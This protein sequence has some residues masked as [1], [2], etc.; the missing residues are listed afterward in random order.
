[1]SKAESGTP[2]TEVPT[3]QESTSVSN[4]DTDSLTLITDQFE[5]DHI[6]GN[7]GI[8]ESYDGALVDTVGGD[9]SEVWFYRG[10]TLY[11]HTTVYRCV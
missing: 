4:V 10:G 11:N 3:V 7:L 6:M 5:V 1:M 8:D 9:Y 2:V